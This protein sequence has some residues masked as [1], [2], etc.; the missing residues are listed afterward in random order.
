VALYRR[1]CRSSSSRRLDLDIPNALDSGKER[2]RAPAVF[3]TRACRSRRRGAQMDSR[4]RVAADCEVY[5][6][7]VVPPD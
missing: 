6:E 7:L 3:Q 4:S 1:D 2:E 5:A